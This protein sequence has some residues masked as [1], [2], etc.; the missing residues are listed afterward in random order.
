[1]DYLESI[2]SRA[3]KDVIHVGLE[4]TLKGYIKIK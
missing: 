2:A 4:V 1:M 3:Q